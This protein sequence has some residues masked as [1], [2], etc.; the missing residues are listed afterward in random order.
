MSMSGLDSLLEA[1]G[2][3]G[4]DTSKIGSKEA[5]SSKKSNSKPFGAGGFSKEN[6][7]DNFKKVSNAKFVQ[8]VSGWSKNK[9]IIAFIFFLVILA[10]AYWWFHPPI[11][12]HSEATWGIIIVFV[13]IP[14]LFIFTSKMFKYKTASSENK[15]TKTI[16]KQKNDK[17][18]A[19]Y[20]KLCL[21]PVSI[22]AIG[23]LGMLLSATFFPGNAERYANVLKTQELDF[24]NDIQQVNYDQIPV[25]DKDT[26]RALGTKEMGTIS[27]YVSQF[28]ISNLYS[29]IN[30]QNKP[31]RVS[32]LGYADLFKWLTNREEGIPAYCLIDMATQNAKIVRISDVDGK[33]GEGIKY[34]YSEPLARN[35]QRYI[36]LKYPFYMFDEFSFEID[37]SGHPWWICP[38]QERTIGLFGGKTITRAVMCDAVTGDCLDLALDEVPQ[39]VDR[40]FPSDLLIE[41]YNWSGRYK[42]GWFNSWLG[43]TGVVKTT[44][45]GT[46]S[47]A[48][49]SGTASISTGLGYN[50]IAKDDDV[51]VYTGVTS[52]TSDSSIVGFILINQRTAESHFYSVSGATEAAAMESAEGQVQQMR[53]AATFPILINIANQPT[54]FISLKDSA[55]LVKKFAMIDIQRYQ[56]VAT[57]DSVSECQKVYLDLLI[58]QGIDTSSSSSSSYSQ[59]DHEATGVIATLT[60]GVVDGNT[61]F[62][63]TLQGD[64]KIYDFAIPGLINIVKYKVGDT[65]HFNYTDGDKT[66]SA[67]S[68]L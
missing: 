5:S 22:I 13:V 59:Y 42:N 23:L 9:K 67:T 48:S 31:V 4:V 52:A 36:Q 21:I 30:F 17:L 68:I 28:E 64:T 11:N 2:N 61:H 25:I 29:Q 7:K 20:K 32:P 60:A 43:Q 49:S 55:G 44:P 26:A 15:T 19:K 35:I 38:V 3:S 57:G 1:L 24:K 56:N 54:Y 45:G 10:I 12:I 6:I 37:D 8:N 34:S 66:C 63:V 14:M 62:Y 40:V 27:D 33:Q 50:Y 47:V 53:Y 46:T 16:L 18:F 41:Q 51:W 65:I 58:K 39:W